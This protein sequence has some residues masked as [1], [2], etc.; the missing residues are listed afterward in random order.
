MPAARECRLEVLEVGRFEIERD[1][2]GAKD[3]GHRPPPACRP[4]AQNAGSVM[5]ASKR[6]CRIMRVFAGIP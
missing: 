5:L 3:S 2:H 6:T 1:A 4:L